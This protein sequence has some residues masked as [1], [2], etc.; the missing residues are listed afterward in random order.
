LISHRIWFISPDAS[1][2][3][4]ISKFLLYTF[5]LFAV[6]VYAGLNVKIVCTGMCLQMGAVAIQLKVLW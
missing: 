3:W 5:L 2:I 4:R 1:P 6:T